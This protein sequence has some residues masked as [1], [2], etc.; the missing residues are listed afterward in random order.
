[1]SFYY[2]QEAGWL[3]KLKVFL[4]ETA[5][6]PCHQVSIRFSPNPTDVWV[7]SGSEKKP[8]LI[9]VSLKGAKTFILH[10]VLMDGGVHKFS[11][12]M[13]MRLMTYSLD[14]FFPC[15][16]LSHYAKASCY[17]FSRNVFDECPFTLLVSDAQLNNADCRMKYFFGRRVKA[18]GTHP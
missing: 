1:M 16:I 11:H 10:R 17:I 4:K 7:L 5:S 2:P 8:L 3:L 12:L 15:F 13:L 9:L 6:V 18:Y 14:H